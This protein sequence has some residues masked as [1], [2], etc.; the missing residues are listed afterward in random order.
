MD[1]LGVILSH[2]ALSLLYVNL[3][4][5]RTCF[6][7]KSNCVSEFLSLQFSLL[8]LRIHLHRFIYDKM[9]FSERSPPSVS[10]YMISELVFCQHWMEVR[11]VSACWIRVG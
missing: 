1:P 5:W 7:D 8:I 6:E 11:K 2:V 3:K 10:L 4:M 9:C